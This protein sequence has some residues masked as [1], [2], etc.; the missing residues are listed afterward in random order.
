[1]S[2]Q[3]EDPEVGRWLNR[4]NWA[5]ASAADRE[6]IVEE[7]RGHLAE[8]IAGGLSP[9][10]ALA[11]FGAAETYARR[12]LDDIELSG[13]LGSQRSGAM[14]SVLAR[15]VHT[16]LVAA[17]GFALVGVLAACAFAAALTAIVKIF[18]PAHAGMWV[19]RGIFMIGVLSDPSQAHELLG[20]W[21]FPAAALV[22]ALAWILGRLV[23]LW[24]LRRIARARDSLLPPSP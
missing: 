4:L 3:D 9:R 14:L 20:N 1:M 6:D 19:G 18:D 5:L 23:L 15:R 10:D 2:A 11:S 13:A 12:F 17:G 8:S 21:I 7:T 16:S 22:V 24:S